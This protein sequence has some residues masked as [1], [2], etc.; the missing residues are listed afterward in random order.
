MID[1]EWLDDLL[2]HISE[3]VRATLAGE[4][5][6][7]PLHELVDELGAFAETLR[8]TWD[9]KL[10]VE[11]RRL[12]VCQP[13]CDTCCKLHAVFVSP[14]EALRLARWLREHRSEEELT[15]L[16][17]RLDEAA[18]IVSEMTLAQRAKARV[19][20]PLLDEHGACSAHPARPL[21]CRAYNSCDRDACLA[22]FQAGDPNTRLL[23]NEHQW[24]VTRT[25]FAALIKGGGQ[26][27]DA[28]PLELIHA[29]RDA[30]TIPDA[31]TRWL[32]GEHVFETDDVRITREAAP[33]W[34]TFVQGDLRRRDLDP[35]S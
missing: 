2:A 20:C 22:A 30:L 31:E 9:E 13:G 16:V 4:L 28:G 15:A 18:F 21:L 29:L 8:A 34:Q 33:R 3:D 6:S 35:S 10:P 5:G 26:G 14:A 7:Q 25:L 11:H 23:V 27:R 12:P 19:P 24:E 32:A 17:K 1:P